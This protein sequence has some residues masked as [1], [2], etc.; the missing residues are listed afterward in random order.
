MSL[1]LPLSDTHAPWALILADGEGTR[2]RPLTRRIAGDTRP[3]QF[4]RAPNQDTLLEQALERSALLISR[5]RTVAVVLGAH[6]RFYAPLLSG[7]PSHAVAVQPANRGTVPAIVYG[8]LRIM[9]VALPGPVAV[10]PCDHHVSND[11]SFMAH[12]ESA[13]QAVAARPDL[14]VLLGITPAAAAEECGWVEPG[15]DIAGPWAMRLQRARRFWDKPSA[16]QAATL[17]ER[18]CLC[19]SVVMVAYP[20]AVL[21]MVAR[22]LPALIDSFAPVRMRLGTPLEEMSLGRVYA[23]L[24]STDFS[25]HVL[26]TCPP[27]LAVLSVNGVEWNGLDVPDRVM[28]TPARQPARVMPRYA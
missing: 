9:A 1:N 6:E 18:G 12:V 21:H 27:N 7:L 8:L 16:A 3:R 5:E 10:F 17:R 28:A 26:A 23:R 25:R 22:S 14:V 15:E 24:P 19:D 20:S 4:C 11:A 13:V 2:R